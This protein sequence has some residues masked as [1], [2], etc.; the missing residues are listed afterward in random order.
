M[1]KWKAFEQVGVKLVSKTKIACPVLYRNLEEGVNSFMGTGPAAA[2]LNQV[3]KK[4]VENKI[5][6]ALQ[7]YKVGEE[8]YH[9]Q[10]SFLLFIAEK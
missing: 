6:S 9:L 7:A 8:S 3:S 2:A 1:V 5:A 4:T 10:N